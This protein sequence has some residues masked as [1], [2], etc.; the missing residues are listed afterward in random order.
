MSE[1]HLHE[2]P[3]ERR[4]PNAR[5]DSERPLRVAV[6][7]DSTTVPAWVSATLSGLRL[8]AFIEMTLVVVDA[9]RRR[10]DRRP[11]RLFAL[12]E[13]LDYRF[14]KSATNAF[15]SVDAAESVGRA[16]VLTGLED[17]STVAAVRSADVDV[18][19][20]LASARPRPELVD[21][22]RFGVWALSLDESETYPGGAPFARQLLD[23]EAVGVTALEILGKERA[24]DRV[25]Y[26]SF[27][28]ID[29]HSL[30]RSRNPVYWKA[31]H[32]MLRQLAHVHEGGWDFIQR[33]AHEE[34][35]G[36]LGREVH[37][38]SNAKMLRFFARL[39]ARALR[40]RLR[41]T[42]YRETWFVAYRRGGGAT[43][44]DD[45]RDCSIVSPSRG[46]YFADPFVVRHDDRHYVFFEDYLTRASSGV[47]SYVELDGGASDSVP[48]IALDRDFH[49]SYPFLFALEG[50]LFMV[51]ET[52]ANRTVEL[53]RA[54]AFPSRWAYEATLLK[55]VPAVD[56]TIV[57]HAGK[58]WLF[59]NV[60][61]HGAH[62]SDEL[63]IFFADSL[64][65]QWT[66]HRRNPV[67]SDVRSARPAGRIFERDGV[68][69]RPGQDSS[70]G[71]GRA[72][73]LNR[74]DVLSEDEYRETPIGRIDHTW[75]KGNLGTHTYNFDDRY[76]VVD[77]RRWEPR[78]RLPLPFRATKGRSLRR[79]ME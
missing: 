35:P 30:Y 21:C 25:I 69:I 73:A 15:A 39:V 9:S 56:A 78:F 6:A 37:R 65:G 38:P 49:L 8:A 44:A 58:L 75:R 14:F 57:S 46:H 20:W 66:P 52:G 28:A 40:S 4:A 68:L 43:S 31:A 74:I 61:E 3:S 12:Y 50:Q 19:L 60:K 7:L 27:S 13:R 2:R 63:C 36:P 33:V 54:E 59:A 23:D 72:V 34:A 48:Q 1:A 45:L 67:V 26:R 32:F 41:K 16:K 76:E 11:S 51:P 70:T 18:V 24:D 53:Y 22:A 77:G 62:Y 79:K 29:P 55:D 64:V 42:L 10:I 47:I 17:A 5:A 71:Y